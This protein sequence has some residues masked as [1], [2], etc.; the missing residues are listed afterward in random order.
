M[1]S[2]GRPSQRNRG[3]GSIIGA[4]FVALILLSGFA[5][6][7]VTQDVTQHYNNTMS[8]MSDMDWNRNQEKIVIKQIGI[9]GT[10]QLNITAEN[11]GSIQSHLIWLGIFNTTATPQNQTY[12]ALNEFVGPDETYSIIS[13]FTVTA[14][15]K[16]VIQLV[17]ELGNTFE[18]KFYP[19]N[20]VG[21]ALTLVTTPP[22]VY[23]GSNITVLLTVTLN[24]TTV[25]SIQTL[26]ATLNATPANLVQLVGSSS[27]FVSGLVR[28]TSAFF[29]WVYNAAN[30]GTVSFNATYMQAPAGTYALST[31][32]IVSPPQQGG[33]GSVTITG[34]NCTASQNPS[35]WNLLGS[36]QNISGSASDLANNDS[37]YAVFRSYYTGKTS[38]AT[39]YV[40]NNLSDV[41]LNLGM[42][43]HSNFTA[44]QY[45]PDSVYD[46][47]TEQA[48]GMVWLWQEDTTV[49]PSGYNPTSS[50]E[51]YEFWSS[52]TTNSTTSGKIT[53]IGIYVFSDPGSNPP[54]VKLGIYDSDSY[55]NPNNLLGQTNTA[56]VAGP[57]WF[58]LDIVGGGVTVSPSTTYYVAHIT[59]RAPTTQWRYRKSASPVSYYNYPTN[60]PNLF[61]PAGTPSQSI[62]YRYG[63][64]RVGYHTNTLDLEVQWTGLNYV[65][66]N[67]SLCIYGGTMAAENLLVDAWNYTG[68]T[69]QNV[70]TNLNPGWNN[71]SVTS[72]LTSSNFTIRYRDANPTD[73]GQNSW[74]IDACLL[75]LSNS[76][77]QYTAEVEF[78]GS[79]N[80][81]SWT[82]LA[83]LVDSSWDT[84]QVNVTIQLYNYTMVSYPS[85]GNGYISYNSSTT[86][87]TDEL[88][89][90]IINSSAIQF[91]NSTS[92]Y[93]WKVKIKGVKST[94]TQFQMKVNWIELQ[95]SYAY[96]GDTVPYKA[97]QWYTIQATGASGN[98]VPFTYASLFANGTTVTF[99]NATDGTPV[100]NPAWL[101]LDANGTFQLQIKSTTSSGETF[102]LSVA[103]G[104]VIQ[105]KTIIQVA[106]Q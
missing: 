14:G 48:G 62:A 92:P 64:Y 65:Q 46:N 101:R 11:D 91:R 88:G 36:T 6:Y 82:Q 105:Q 20:Y 12:Q 96:T 33:Q 2:I 1:R 83:W 30:T 39:S 29:W 103:V 73:T 40:N 66:Q 61:S 42:G 95:N 19:A 56:T 74:Q 49:G 98:P 15:N 23:Q 84:G 86:P 106:Q 102:V 76:T 9:T 80:Q 22:T 32:Q 26:T 85:S 47:L 25:D 78:T 21:C 17:T 54:Q 104:T 94:S 34:V 90:Q 50:Y 27:L 70:F 41:D 93:Y 28:G 8:S 51:T 45:G 37:N 57:G 59:N 43:T 3:I 24:D 52:W 69:W 89:S 81:Q 63:A 4:V 5:F 53:T 72:L 99:Q 87:N 97:W 38:Y 16:Y 44:E 75:Q 67:V 7:A 18:S 68:S 77:D 10:N 79:S 55:G 71:Q 60:W 13:N 100:S 58:D 35:Q 31:A